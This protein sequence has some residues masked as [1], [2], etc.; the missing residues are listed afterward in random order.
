MEDLILEERLE[1]LR[2]DLEQMKQPS[3]WQDELHLKNVRP[4]RE[5]WLPHNRAMYQKVEARLRTLQTIQEHLAQA[6][7]AED[8]DAA[9][10]IQQAW[11]DYTRLY[12]DSQEIFRETLELIGGLALRDKYDDDRLFIF[13]DELIHVCA[14][15][16][17]NQPALTVPAQEEALS[18]TVGRMV[19]LRFPDWSVWTLPFVAHEFGH[20][21][22]DEKEG[23]RRLVAE[24]V[25]TLM[26]QES[27][28][29]MLS[30]EDIEKAEDRADG[31][32][33]C[34]TEE[35]A[36][37]L[38]DAFN[39]LPQTE[40]FQQGLAQLG[41]EHLITLMAS[42]ITSY[43]HQIEELVADAFATYNM[44]P[45][46]ACSALLI[47]FNPALAHH[48]TLEHPGDAKRA[49]V[50]IE[51]L[52]MLNSAE[53]GGSKSRVGPYEAVISTLGMT[54]SDLLVRAGPQGELGDEAKSYLAQLTARIW[55]GFDD[56]YFIEGRYPR[57]YRDL[58]GWEI[59]NNWAERWS[60][61]LEERKRLELPEVQTTSKLRDALNAAWC[62]R[63]DYPD[64][65][66]E[67]TDATLELCEAIIE[68]RSAGGSPDLKK[69]SVRG[70]T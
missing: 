19:R 15:S 60:S 32:K 39:V 40:D 18:M 49:L 4:E 35:F 34:T 37:V 64:R 50:I 53:G 28:Y 61:C 45:A 48:D 27:I 63:L 24:E 14:K 58:E 55:Q 38:Y 54:W 66:R 70:R 6:R 62:C 12:Q 29:Q 44:G 47:R 9:G 17:F 25:K 65:V 67:I 41:R 5:V 51:M 52:K 68:K 11:R 33:L 3:I 16:T 36:G 43:T 20:V 1:A 23:V 42:K 26:Q 31:Y 8:A 59:A 21:V 2:Q 10:M 7:D 56:E 13:A 22:I 57:N 46:Y 30:A 69:G